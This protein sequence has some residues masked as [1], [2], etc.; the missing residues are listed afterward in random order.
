[1][2]H[3]S[4]AD[5]SSECKRLGGSSKKIDSRISIAIQECIVCAHRGSNFT[6]AK[7]QRNKSLFNKNVLI[8][9]RRVT[10]HR[11]YNPGQYISIPR[12]SPF[13][14]LRCSFHY[15]A[16]LNPFFNLYFNVKSYYK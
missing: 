7:V 4:F 2:E 16:N 9:R 13:S 11:Y 12:V 3:V 5:M 1:M 14:R 15:Q 10:N 8:Q 6:T